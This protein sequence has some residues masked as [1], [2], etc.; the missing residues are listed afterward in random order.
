VVDAH[1]T[2]PRTSE[3]PPFIEAEHTAPSTENVCSVP[4][5]TLKIVSVDAKAREHEMTIAFGGTELTWWWRS[6]STSS[7]SNP[8]IGTA[9]TFSPR[10]R[11]Y[12]LL[13]RTNWL[14]TAVGEEAAACST[15]ATLSTSAGGVSGVWATA[16]AA[17]DVS[18][19]RSD[20]SGL[21]AASLNIN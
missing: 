16:R 5:G 21:R 8:R 1:S 12:A 11:T 4:G 9:S 3:W 15:T 14:R 7:V 10:L 2:E 20:A 18:G 19:R 17:S 13:P 6:V